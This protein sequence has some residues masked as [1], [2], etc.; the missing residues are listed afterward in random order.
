[1]PVT[2]RVREV[3]TIAHMVV[4]A[5]VHVV[6]AIVREVVAIVR[7]VVVAIVRVR[8]VCASCHCG[9]GVRVV[10]HPQRRAVG[11]RAAT[12]R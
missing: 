3:V 11:G 10:F 2:S 9:G 4:V 8:V 5:I 6:V 7:E 1:M 12:F